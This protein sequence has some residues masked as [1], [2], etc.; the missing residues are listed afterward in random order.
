MLITPSEW[1]SL[2]ISFRL[3]VPRAD[4]RHSLSHQDHLASTVTRS[5]SG[6]ASTCGSLT[7]F[8][9]WQC[10]RTPLTALSA[11]VDDSMIQGGKPEWWPNHFLAFLLQFNENQ[12]MVKSG[13]VDHDVLAMA[14]I[15]YEAQKATL[16]AAIA[17]IQAQLSRRAP[18]SGPDPQI[19]R[20]RT[21]SA[22]G[23]RR[24][25]AAQRKRWTALRKAKQRTAATA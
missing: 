3:P 8:G 6:T 21:M 11:E 2:H 20:K 7:R 4:H 14:L 18:S 19:P 1:D 17:G 25:A 15:G 10:G 24:I 12:S 9:R 22:A 5:T 13:R 23:K 16:D